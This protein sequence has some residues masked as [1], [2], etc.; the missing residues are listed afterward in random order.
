MADSSRTPSI[1][2]SNETSQGTLPKDIPVLRKYVL[3]VLFCLADF[4]DVFNISSL[5]S[6]IPKIASDLDMNAGESVWIISAVQLTFASFLLAVCVLVMNIGC[7]TLTIVH[8]A[9]ELATYT[10]PVCCIARLFKFKLWT[11]YVIQSL[12]SSLESWVSD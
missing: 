4:V 5:F 6:A 12:H 10:I 1:I 9:E 8:R 11:D 7:G 3:L 2:S